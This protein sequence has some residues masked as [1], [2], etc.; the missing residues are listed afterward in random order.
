MENYE[1][2]IYFRRVGFGHR[3][4]ALII[5]IVIL[6]IIGYVFKMILGIKDPTPEELMGG[7]DPENIDMSAMMMTSIKASLLSYIIGVLYTSMEIFLRKTPGKM[8]LG[9]IVTNENGEIPTMNAMIIR[10]LFKQISTILLI[11]AILLNV[12]SLIWVASLLGIVFLIGCF[13]ALSEKR[14][15]LHDM[16][17][18]T[19]VYKEKELEEIGA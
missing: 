15:A 14:M 1:E 9:L 8:A 3:F 2:D 13:F 17:A 5:D 11:M 10:Y 4:G 16:I 6:M 12:V 7:M 18:K 19:A